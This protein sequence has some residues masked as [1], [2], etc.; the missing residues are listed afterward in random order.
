MLQHIQNVNQRF[1]IEEHKL[2]SN[3]S[4]IIVFET[5]CVGRH[6]TKDKQVLY[7]AYKCSWI[8]LAWFSSTFLIGFQFAVISANKRTRVRSY[9]WKT[10]W[11]SYNSA[12]IW[13]CVSTWT[14]LCRQ[15]TVFVW[16][17]F[18][19]KVLNN[20]NECYVDSYSNF[21][22]L[23]RKFC[24]HVLSWESCLLNSD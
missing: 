17:L 15:I 19:I 16:L 9:V 14:Q 11:E 18:L 8:Q 21:K 12:W 24:K 1:Q 3:V 13:P 23:F 6:R 20:E 4:A 2:W 5:L 7:V 22:K 10:M